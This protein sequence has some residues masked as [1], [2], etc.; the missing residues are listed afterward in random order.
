MGIIDEC[1]IEYICIRST[2]GIAFFGQDRTFLPLVFGL[3]HSHSN[4]GWFAQTTSMSS[5]ISGVVLQLFCDE[6]KKGST[7]LLVV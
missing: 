5:D 7:T 6:L 2:D 3:A 1:V 4:L